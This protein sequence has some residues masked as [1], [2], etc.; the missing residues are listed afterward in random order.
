M[1]ATQT[2]AIAEAAH[3]GD[4]EANGATE[5][6]EGADSLVQNA[7][8]HRLLE[9]VIPIKSATSLVVA[10]KEL[11]LAITPDHDVLKVTSRILA[12]ACRK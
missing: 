8:W 10:A 3:S 9:R 7:N 12:D 11:P 6:R 4:L 5:E 2:L 1:A